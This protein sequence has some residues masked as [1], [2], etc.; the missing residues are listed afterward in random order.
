MLVC[1]TSAAEIHR[2][3]R[4]VFKISGDESESEPNGKKPK[5]TLLLTDSDSDANDEDEEEDAPH[6]YITWN[7]CVYY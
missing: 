3:N 5:M 4:Q 1:R 7:S 6:K 2:K